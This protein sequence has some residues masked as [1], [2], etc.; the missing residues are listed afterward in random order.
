MCRPSFALAAP[1]LIASLTGPAVSAQGPSRN[2]TVSFGA[3]LNTTGA[4]N[5][6]IIP[7]EINIKVG[8]II[9]FNVAGLHQIF[10]YNPGT[11]PEEIQE[12]IEANNLGAALFIN[13]MDGLYY[14]GINPSLVL[15]GVL[16][17]GVNDP[18]LVP[19]TPPTNPPTNGPLL[20]ALA[21]DF[22]ASRY[23]LKHLIRTI[24]TSYVYGLSSLPTERNMSDRQNY[25][26]HYRT[27]LR[28][29]VLLDAVSDITGIGDSFSVTGEHW[30]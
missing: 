21:A 6:H 15:G 11:T 7:Q 30:L 19:G 25:S 27:R 24:C 22:R 10:V 26:R 1:L 18:D 4:A 9:N 17:P 28:G 20:D 5:H 29:E 12:Y 8:D 13:R 2:V 14:T 16:V 23:D 3:G